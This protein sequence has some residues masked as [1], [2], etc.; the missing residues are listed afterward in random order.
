MRDMPM[1]RRLLRPSATLLMSCGLAATLAGGALAA[2]KAAAKPAATKPG[3]DDPLF[4]A[5]QWREIGPFRGGRV[6]AVTG[7]ANQPLTYYFGGT[8][9][10]VWKT[11]DGGESWKNVSDGF[12]GG[13]IGAVAVAPSDPNVIYVGGGEVTV[14]G[15]VSAGDG[16]W[17]STDGGATWARSGLS[18]A[19]QI[20]RLRVHP[21]DPNLV[22]AAV[23]GHT[24]G[25]N[26][27]RGVFRS[28]DGG[29]T[30]QRVLF[31]SRD[32]GAVDL[33]MDPTN[34]RIL[35]ATTWRFRRT[36]WGFDSGGEGS[37]LWKSTDGGD[38][39]KNLTQN[40]T[41]KSGLPK[42]TLGIMGITVSPSNSQNLYAIIEADEGGVFRSRDGGETWTK[43]NES[44]DLRQRAWYY[45]R[46]YADPKDED[47]VYVVNVQF[48]KSKDGGKS[49]STIRTPH[50]DNHDLWIAPDDPLRMIE[51][52]DGGAQVSFDGGRTWTSQENQ[53]TAQFYR[54]STD[55][56]F[57]YRILGAQQD[58]SAVRIRS[59]SDDSGIGPRDWDVTAGGES[60]YI[61]ADPRDSDIVFGGSYGGL[62]TVVNHR[63]NEVRDVNPWPDN[64]MGWGAAELKYRFQWNF[65]I[66]FSPNDPTVLYAGANV[67]FR[68]HDR[69]ASWEAI[70]PDLTRDDKTKEGPAGGPITKDNTSVEYY[71]TVFAVAESPVEPGVIWAGSDDGLV[72]VTR[73]NGKT[74]KKVTPAGL[75]EWAQINAI[76]ASP[77]EKGVAYVAATRYKLDDNRPYL[78]KTRD[79]G[80]TWTEIDHGIPADQFTRVVRSD[81]KRQGLL[82][83]GTE[84]GM[85]MS[86]DDGATW[87]SLQLKLPIVPITDLLVKG[88]D[89]IAATQGRAFWVLDDIGPLREMTAPVASET[90]HV[91]KPTTVYRTQA[92]GGFF[93]PR[94]QGANPPGGVV[95]AYSLVGVKDGTPL[96]LE[97][98]DTS[99][100]V[101]RTFHGETAKEDPKLEAKPA[102]EPAPMSPVEGASPQ[103]AS[104]KEALQA[105][106]S[107]KPDAMKT[108]KPD[109]IKSAKLDS[110]DKKPKVKEGEPKVDGL[111]GLNRFVWNLETEA[112]KGFPGLVLWAGTDLT[113]PRVLPG[114]YQA[115]LTVGEGAE[116]KTQTVAFTVKADPRSKTTAAELSAQYDF[117]L[118]I[119]DK[120]TA[121]HTEIRRIR[122]V[123]SQLDALKEKVGEDEKAKPIVEAAEALDKKMKAV[124]ESLY[125][126]KNKSRQDPLNYPVRL[127]DKLALL[128]SSA[129]TGDYPPTAQAIAIKKQ[130]DA[131]IDEQLARIKEVWDKDLPAL[132]DL[133]KKSDVPA[134]SNEVKDDD[135]PAPAGRRRGG[136]DEDGGSER[137]F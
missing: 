24:F 117:L 18:D 132:N 41:K 77:L 60:G 38:T 129:S 93:V 65:P 40:V 13:S 75:P 45:S 44:R 104:A 46:I 62:L 39:W 57:P 113:G 103:K 135:T 26:D 53:P 48:H 64:P 8:G 89:L 22:Y 128:G 86:F 52:N 120:L 125:Q 81:T 71:A 95:L 33:A 105:D 72:H 99:G 11:T 137:D 34:P 30:W 123:R 136:E 54:V 5:M 23:L 88:D 63:T 42:G 28:K 21:E 74:W 82:F 100:K 96:K 124:E 79:Y 59:R 47:A 94:N 49:F 102:G 20:P 78:F 110:K 69:G 134:V 31:A 7:I 115:R 106:A 56:D 118:A 43:T 83:A 50:G 85:W 4:K 66:C 114:D 84:R 131:Q 37:A 25:P 1:L 17:K 126:T 6:A 92:G 76:D 68:S 58:N 116:A 35:Y 32:A 101:L 36:P 109:A 61:V 9:G 70:S 107:A 97:F 80:T 10:G 67:V 130:L 16:M 121:M 112:A 19:G 127:N 3:F 15:N 90:V 2:D 27:Q 98:L 55:N 29:K 73:D 122:Q 91:F 119:R 51:S 12:F 108:E 87:Q 111:P 14:R 133:V